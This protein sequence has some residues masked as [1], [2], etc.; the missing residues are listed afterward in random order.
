MSIKVEHTWQD[1]SLKAMLEPLRDSF[2]FFISDQEQFGIGSIIAGVPP[3]NQSL[4]PNPSSIALL[5]EK[6]LSMSRIIV[7]NLSKKLQK[8][9]VGFVDIN[10]NLPEIKLGKYIVELLNL[11]YEE[12]A[13]SEKE[14]K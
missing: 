10:S 4:I 12:L 7:R 9:V 13:K 8:P 6:N 11:L 5:G 2:L 3:I 14:T 1:L